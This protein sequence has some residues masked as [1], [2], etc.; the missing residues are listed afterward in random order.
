MPRFNELFKDYTQVDNVKLLDEKLPL[1]VY[2]GRDQE[3]KLCIAFTTPFSAQMPKS[4]KLLEFAQYKVGSTFW[5]YVSLQDEE[6]RSTFYAFC[7]DIVES[8]CTLSD[9]KEAFQCILD[10]IR[11]WKRM[12]ASKSGLLSEIAIQGLFG[13]LYFIDEYLIPK[14][15]MEKAIKS[16]GGPLGMPKDFSLG[17]EWFEVK[18]MSATEE[19]VHI[20][21]HEQL[22][23]DNPGHL[24]VVKIERMPEAFNNGVST[25]NALFEKVKLTLSSMP[26]ILDDFV[27]KLSKLGYTPDDYYDKFRYKT[28]GMNFYRVD[29][30]FPRLTSPSSFG[31]AISAISYWLLINALKPY[32][33]SDEQWKKTF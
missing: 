22:L 32:L 8:I 7:E 18:C 16:W 14:F 2:Y 33:E 23:S 6:I 3:G 29:D 31:S 17:L 11:I 5:T 4:T 25:I 9:D 26:E 10:R 28:I 12:F 21:S 20:S 13:E 24:T 1:D 15:G 30:R 19:S 27:M